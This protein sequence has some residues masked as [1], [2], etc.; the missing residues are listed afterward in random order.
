ML[1]HKQT[2][3][4]PGKGTSVCGAFREDGNQRFNTTSW[5]RVTCPD[6]RASR[7]KPWLARVY[8]QTEGIEFET[9]FASECEGLAFIEGYM[10]AKEILENG[11]CD[12]L[13]DYE[14]Y[15]VHESKD[16]AVEEN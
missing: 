9:T 8:H 12:E 6:C 10:A 3:A 16:E 15:V 2:K 5:R 4:N 1:T 14:A 11:D 7:K 13:E